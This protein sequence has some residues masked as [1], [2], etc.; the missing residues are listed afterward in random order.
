MNGCT[1]NTE[2]QYNVN[3]CILPICFYN[4]RNEQ[5]RIFYWLKPKAEPTINQ[6]CEP[7]KAIFLKLKPMAQ[8]TLGFFSTLV[9]KPNLSFHNIY[10]IMSLF[11]I[12]QVH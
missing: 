11:L 6:R 12:P 9:P 2:D 10:E 8:K 1:G 5:Y 4:F 3:E 7:K